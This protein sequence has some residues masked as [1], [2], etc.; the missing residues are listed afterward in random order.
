MTSELQPVPSQQLVPSAPRSTM[1]MVQE[2]LMRG[3]PPEILGKMMDL[4]DRYEA[5][6]AR[7]AFYEAKTAFKA[8]SLVVLKDKTN[9]QFGSKYSSIGSVVNPVNEALSKHG[10][11]A[12]WDIEQSEKSIKV[13][14]ILT[15]VLGYS[16]KVPLSG[17]PDV[18]GQKNH[19]QQI[20]STLTY[21]KLATFEAVTGIATQDGN[22]DD[23]GNAAGNAPVSDV[24]AA[25]LETLADDTGADRIRF[26]RY[27]KIDRIA[28]LPAKEFDKAKRMLEGKK[29]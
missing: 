9:S 1:E 28:D 19:I 24:Q 14:C 8:I 29:K 17:P 18:S 13:T 3:L 6:Q 7:K 5:G 23:D 2:A 26:C 22:A 25:A 11:D 12:R 21:L 27:F 20:K 16:E 4:H 10:L 15:H